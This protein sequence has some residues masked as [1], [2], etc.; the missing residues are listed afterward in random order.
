M[1]SGDESQLTPRILMYLAELRKISV[2]QCH[3][4]TRIKTNKPLP[5]PKQLVFI[6]QM[7]IGNSQTL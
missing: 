4:K 7:A 3:F 5:K 2:I 1:E 6:H